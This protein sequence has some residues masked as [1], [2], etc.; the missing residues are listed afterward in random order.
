MPPILD[1]LALAILRV[2]TRNGSRWAARMLAEA[3]EAADVL[4]SVPEAVVGN[5]IFHAKVRWT[6]EQSQKGHTK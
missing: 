4:G 1:P 3:G 2:A 5:P 6:P